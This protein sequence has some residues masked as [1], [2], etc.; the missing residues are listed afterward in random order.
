[1]GKPTLSEHQQM[2]LD[3]LNDGLPVAGIYGHTVCFLIKEGFVSNVEKTLNKRL[4]EYRVIKPIITG[5][6]PD[7]SETNGSQYHGD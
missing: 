7:Y 3:W 5:L 6:T 2:I 4:V 1:M